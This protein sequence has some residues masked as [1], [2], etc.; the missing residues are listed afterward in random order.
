MS[1]DIDPDVARAGALPP[2][3]YTDPAVLRREGERVFARTWQ[4]VARAE[5]LAEIGAYAAVQLGGEPVVIV[6]G[7]DGLRGY[8]N[9]C[10]HR[11]GPLARGCGKRRTIQCGYHGWTFGLDGAL[12]HAPEIDPAD[13]ADV[14]LAPIAVAAWGPLVFAAIEPLVPLAEQLAGIAA[15]SEVRFVMRRDYELDCNWKVY[16]D[17]YLEGYHIPVVHP[18]LHKELDYDRYRT[19]TDRWWSRQ[20]A[21]LRPLPADSRARRYRPAHEGEEAEY[22]W[23][24]PNLMLN[25]YQGQLQTNVVVPLGVERTRVEFEW[26]AAAPPADPHTDPTWQNLVGMS[27]LLQVQDTAICETVQRNLRSRGARRGRYAARRENGVHHFHALLA[28]LLR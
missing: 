24:F 18:E 11:A 27:D 13:V 25:I 3:L 28:E 20:F 5:A 17:N 21:P 26:F 14:R 12:L 2:E 16:V 7:D 23:A 9:V 19:V 15:P 10:P 6:R 4:L 1:F 22:Y 8:F